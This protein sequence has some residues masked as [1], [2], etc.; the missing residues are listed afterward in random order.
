M[1]IYIYIYIFPRVRTDVDGSDGAA[2][3]QRGR[4]VVAACGEA[5]R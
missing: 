2:H 1:Y 3:T 4:F 5:V